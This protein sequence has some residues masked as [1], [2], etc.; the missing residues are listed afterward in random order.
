MH[1]EYIVKC[2]RNGWFQVLVVI[3]IRLSTYWF[4]RSSYVVSKRITWSGH[5]S[6]IYSVPSALLNWFV[7]YLP[8]FQTKIVYSNE[9]NSLAYISITDI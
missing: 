7:A 6:L 3:L 1:G 4:L 9:Y 8:S 2:L 5:V